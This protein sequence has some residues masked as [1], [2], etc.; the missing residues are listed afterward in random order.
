MIDLVRIFNRGGPVE[1]RTISRSSLERSEGF[2]ARLYQTVRD[3]PELSER[4]IAARVFGEATGD[5]RKFTRLKSR[6]KLLLLDSLPFLNLE[7]GEYSEYLG[8][9][10]VV[11]RS[12]FLAQILLLLSARDLAASIA[13]K[14]LA[15]AMRIEEWNNAMQ[16]LLVLRADAMHKRKPKLY[17]F[18]AEEYLH[19]ER[20]LAAENL[21]KVQTEQLQ[22]IFTR[23]AGPQPEQK[24]I[25]AEAASKAD[26][27]ARS[28]PSFKLS[29]S[30]L[31][32]RSIAAQLHDEYAGTIAIC[33][34]TTLLL[35]RYPQFHTKAR[36]GEFAIDKLVAAIHIRCKDEAEKAIA[37]CRE[38]IERSKNNW[39][40]YRE[41][42][43]LHLMHT[44]RFHEAMAVV[45][46]IL[47]HPRFSS[48][49][50]MASER[51][52]LFRLYAEYATGKRVP[53]RDV[54]D[55]VRLLPTFSADKTGLN[56]SLVILHVLLMAER[57]QF[58]DLGDRAEFIRGYRKR[59]LRGSE[60]SHAAHFFKMLASIEL[61]DMSLKKLDK[62]SRALYL[63]L[64]RI[65]REEPIQGE[66]ILPYTWV[67]NR[68]RE[69]LREYHPLVP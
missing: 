47:S 53:I 7:R 33:N 63:E 43:F 57:G 15:K 32:L 34:E 55:F 66:V 2:Q 8:A 59:F 18:Y 68:L 23:H 49:S 3:A 67:W 1:A 11:A 50:K 61:S 17:R 29:F 40:V 54:G 36:Q 14:A 21:S 12:S 45:D 41:F 6:L 28:N 22:M 16:L 24:E 9:V 26:T 10:Y 64:M 13:R 31:R 46:D 5:A 56:T 44:S 42:E 39:F 20:L 69:L 48:L 52:Q 30:A 65:E 35:D 37:E 19:C 62:R 51:W 4:E 27:L 60:H 58:A 38:C 25:A